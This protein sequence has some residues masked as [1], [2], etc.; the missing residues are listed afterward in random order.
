MASTYRGGGG[1]FT[2]ERGP[3][4]SHPWPSE[5]SMG[6]EGF[7][8]IPSQWQDPFGRGTGSLPDAGTGKGR[9]TLPKDVGTK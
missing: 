7:D 4:P 6:G 9:K 1:A 8:C 5:T 3:R 2:D